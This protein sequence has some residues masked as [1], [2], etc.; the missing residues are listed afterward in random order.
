MTIILRCHIPRF[1]VLPIVCSQVDPVLLP[2]LNEYSVLQA[3]SVKQLA[4]TADML[5]AAPESAEGPIVQLVAEEG[6]QSAVTAEAAAGSSCFTSAPVI[7]SAALSQLPLVLGDEVEVRG[8]S[9]S[10]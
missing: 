3:S 6:V 4:G 5:P 2:I 10:E 8:Y 7:P 9:T 1:L